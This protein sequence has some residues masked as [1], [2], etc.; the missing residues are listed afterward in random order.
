MGT[1]TI[2]CEYIWL[3][4]GTTQ[5]LRSKTRVITLQAED[6]NWKL[7]L[8]DIPV[9]GFDGSSTGQATTEASDC[10]LITDV[11]NPDQGIPGLTTCLR[12]LIQIKVSIRKKKKTKVNIDAQT[13]LYK[14]LA[15]LINND[16]SLAIKEISLA[17][18]PV[19]EKEREG[20]AQ[21]PTSVD[22]LRK[23]G[24]LLPETVLTVPPD[25]ESIVEAQ[26]RKSY[27]NVRP[28]N[29]VSGSVIFGSAAVRL[30]VIVPDGLSNDILLSLLQQNI[31]RLNRFQLKTLIN[32]FSKDENLLIDFFIQSSTKNPHSGTNGGPFPVAELQLAK[33]LDRLINNKGFLILD[34]LKTSK[35]L[36]ERPLLYESAAGY[37]GDCYADYKSDPSSFGAGWMFG[38]CAHRTRDRGHKH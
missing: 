14:I 33:I 9:W 4:G 29:R 10:V 32:S 37:A 27:I 21:I 23:T 12:G 25:R 28:G 20:F 36:L 22:F 3:D 15:A 30:K 38:L 6:E 17:D 8:S 24:G 11:I 34:D 7:N 13:A 5:Q 26:L 35:K 2:R 31:D 1:A 19:T 18:I 16:H